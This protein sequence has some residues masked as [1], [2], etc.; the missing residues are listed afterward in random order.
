M[1]N[2]NYTFPVVFW[3]EKKSTKVTF[4]I[5]Q[6]LPH[7][8][9]AIT[10]VMC[11]VFS[12]NKILLV[13]PKRGWGLPGGHVEKDESPVDA[14]K[15]ECAEEAAIEIKNI[16][17]IGF[18]EA[19]KIVELKTNKQYPKKG[20]QLLFMADLD[21]MH[22]FENIFEVDDRRFVNPSDVAEL[23]HSFR[24]FKEILRYIIDERTVKNV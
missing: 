9:N 12:D 8:Q 14:I 23:H 18:W 15:R 22:Q 10:S 11:A 6:K 19:N 20:Y 4:Q 17:F 5:S 13:K 2:I 3:G 21:K 7:E 1:N 24:N 16:K